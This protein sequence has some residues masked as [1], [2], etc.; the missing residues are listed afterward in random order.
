MYHL[1]N[2]MATGAEVL[3]WVRT[4]AARQRLGRACLIAAPALLLAGMAAWQALA[5]N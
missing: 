3:G 2:G 4:P 5:V 1:T